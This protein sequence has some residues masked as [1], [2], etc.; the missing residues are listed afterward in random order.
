MRHLRS[1]DASQ[2][3][4][5]LLAQLAAHVAW[6]VDFKFKKE[7]KGGLFER[8]SAHLLFFLPIFAHICSPFFF[9]SPLF[10]KDDPAR[11]AALQQS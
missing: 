5:P 2:L 9:F 6:A 8:L 7:G 4:P 3:A 1:A 11:T 10:M